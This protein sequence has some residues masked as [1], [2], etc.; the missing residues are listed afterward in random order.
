M[1]VANVYRSHHSQTIYFHREWDYRTVAQQ[2]GIVVR[3][4]EGLVYL[5]D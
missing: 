2:K 4:S 1:E 5:V 3:K